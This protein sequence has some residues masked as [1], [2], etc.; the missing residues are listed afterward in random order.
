MSSTERWARLRRATFP[1]FFVPEFMN[2]SFVAVVCGAYTALQ[3]DGDVALTAFA[4]LSTLHGAEM[5]LARVGGWNLD[6]R[7]PFALLA[8]D[9]LLPVMFVDALLF[10]D[11]VWHGNSMTVREEEEPTTTA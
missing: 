6:W 9:V 7:T 3:F 1:A 8:R 4:I 2:G 10:D 11:F 5:A